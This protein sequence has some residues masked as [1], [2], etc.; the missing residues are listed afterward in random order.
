MPTDDVLDIS[1][2]DLGV[3]CVS[4]GDLGEE[5][6]LYRYDPRE[7]VWLGPALYIRH[8][9]VFDL[10]VYYTGGAMCYFNGVA[11]NVMYSCC[12]EYKCDYGVSC[13]DLKVYQDVAVGDN[14]YSF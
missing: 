10:S 14:Y 7:D 3:I 13:L 5:Y 9:K 2:S 11:E 6:N 8:A 4:G 12:L 1:V